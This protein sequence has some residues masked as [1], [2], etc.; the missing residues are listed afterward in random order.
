MRNGKSLFSSF[1]ILYLS[2][3]LSLCG[4]VFF[5]ASCAS[6]PK[7]SFPVDDDDKELSLLPEGARA[8]LWVDAVQGR[9]LLDVFSFEGM[10]VSDVPKQMLDRTDSVAAA[11]FQDTPERSFFLA[12]RGS[13]PSAWTNFS[14]LFNRSW[15]KQ[16]SSVEGSYWYSRNDN[17]A[18]ALGPKLVLVSDSDPYEAS[19][20]VIA[21]AGFSGFRR[22]HVMAGWMNS[23]AEPLSNFL[24]SLGIPLQ[25]PAVDFFFGAAKMPAE[26]E[27]ELWEL[28]FRV[29]TPS[30]T[31]ARGILSLFNIARLYVL[32]SP[33]TDFSDED[34]YISPQEAARLLLA[35][36]PE[37][38]GDSLIL[39][40]A[41]MNATRLALLFNMF[42]VYSN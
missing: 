18:L 20:T 39:R 15:K 22:T 21:P 35:N 30:S 14:L 32:R 2:I 6:A 16:K 19:Q 5:L 12:A 40:T 8:Y 4:S 29:R 26:A 9:P 10:S 27:I 31:H 7:I 34:F 38:E 37:L 36:S 13:Y 28:I 17:L 41:S 1:P 23:P 42:L 25:I 33:E 11:L 24:V 3:I